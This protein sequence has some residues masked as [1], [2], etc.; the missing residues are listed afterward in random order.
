MQPRRMYCFTCDSDERHRALTTD[1]KVWLKALT[2]RRT[3]EEFFMCGATGCRNLRT[4]F[5]KRPFDPVIRVPLP[6]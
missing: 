2:G 3:V 5:N 6:D 4:G 1:E